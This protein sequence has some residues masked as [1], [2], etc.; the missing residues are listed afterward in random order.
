M[1]GGA[2]CQPLP[3]AGVT[4]AASGWGDSAV[5]A[6]LRGRPRRRAAAAAGAG[7]S[8]G[9]ASEAPGI[10]P[11]SGDARARRLRGGTSGA[12]VSDSG[13]AADPVDASAAAV[14]L[15]RWRRAGGG[16]VASSA[17]GTL[18]SAAPRRRRGAG[19]VSTCAATAPSLAAPTAFWRCSGRLIGQGLVSGSRLLGEKMDSVIRGTVYM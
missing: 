14:A 19:V 7:V 11:G 1:E 15:R 4:S 18:A 6:S 9:P 5:A 16:A 10:P 3:R 2:P 12:D 13:A 8:A 17:G